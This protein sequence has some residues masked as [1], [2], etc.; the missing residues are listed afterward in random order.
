MSHPSTDGHLDNALLALTFAKDLL[1]ELSV[2]TP[3]PAES[4][5]KYLQ[6]EERASQ[7]A[8][9]TSKLALRLASSYGTRLP[10]TD[11]EVRDM[12][13]GSHSGLKQNKLIDAFSRAMRGVPWNSE[14]YWINIL[15]SWVSLEPKNF[16]NFIK[17]SLRCD[18]QSKLLDISAKTAAS[19][20]YTFT[21][22]DKINAIKY[23]Q[24]WNQSTKS[25]KMKHFQ[26]EFKKL[27][28]SEFNSL[29]DD[30]SAAKLLK[31][32]SPF[33]KW[34]ARRYREIG[35]RNALAR[36]YSQFGAFIILDP[37][38]SETDLK[39]TRFSR[40]LKATNLVSTIL[41]PL[42]LL[43]FQPAIYQ[44]LGVLLSRLAG[45]SIATHVSGFLEDTK[46][47][48]FSYA[49]ND[50]ELEEEQASD[51]EDSEDSSDEEDED[52]ED[53]F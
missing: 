53:E 10:L 16:A 17:Q 35:A 13:R 38:W 51:P 30:A 45:E 36:L 23:A 39:D 47:D 15:T 19:K 33:K 32:Q 50:T 18:S 8:E 7:A 2:D 25:Q 46:D 6:P 44:L 49:A 31:M 43:D 20:T 27:H 29:S 37:A 28:P 21:V 22:I 4:S 41:P 3:L 42:A 48:L 9:A 24:D 12:L 5:A 11:D 34:K 14:V 52:D 40:F 1:T 26:A